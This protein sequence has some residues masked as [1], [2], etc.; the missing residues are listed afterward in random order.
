MPL[1]GVTANRLVEDEVHR[2]WVRRRYID[3]L[4]TFANVEIVVLPTQ[5]TND[6]VGIRKIAD[7]L[8]GLVLTGDESN[9]NPDYV[10]QSNARRLFLTESG[11][12]RGESD[13]YRDVMASGF[14]S[15]ALERGLPILGIC[16]GLQEMNVFFGGALFEDISSRK[17]MLRHR[18]DV[19]LPRD[20]QYD[21]V[22]DVIIQPGGKFASIFGCGTLIKVNS[23]HNQGISSLGNGLTCE[24]VAP[25][26][27]IE[28]IS[29]ANA[30]AL[31]LAV[32]WHPEWHAAEDPHSKRLF[33]AFGKACA[34]YGSKRPRQ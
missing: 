8:D 3:T 17:D 14:L 33:G 2:E 32:Q 27:L 6:R 25:D 4:E 29:V 16:R 28:A 22:H 11:Y 15:A 7:R 5:S 20:R 12:R 21:P 26:G 18:E 34:D 19:S 31:Q 24:A 9:V 30:D 1:V 23:L 10:S 13:H